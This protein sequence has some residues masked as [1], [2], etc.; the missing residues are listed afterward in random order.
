MFRFL[1]SVL[2]NAVAWFVFLDW[3]WKQAEGQIDKMQAAAFNTPGAAAPIPPAVVGVGTGVL[4]GHV[5]LSSVLRLG[6]ERS[7]LSLLLGGAA[8]TAILVASP[9]RP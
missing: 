7:W 9:R 5:L 1:V 3:S 8:G 2:L 4:L 6:A